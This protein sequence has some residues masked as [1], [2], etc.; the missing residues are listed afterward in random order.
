[1]NVITTNGRLII[2]SKRAIPFVIITAV[3][4]YGPWPKETKRGEKEIISFS[5]TNVGYVAYI[6]RFFF[7]PFS[8]TIPFPLFF[9][10]FF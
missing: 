1:M 4:F 10:F 2:F 9:F 3:N 6:F 7:S 5:F 8:L